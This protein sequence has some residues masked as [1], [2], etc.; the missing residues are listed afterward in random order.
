MTRTEDRYANRRRVWPWVLGVVLVVALAVAA[1][2]YF[3][4]DSDAPEARA[5]VVSKAYRPLP[6]AC[7]DALALAR[8]MAAHVG[9]LSAAVN[10]HADLMERLDL[11]LEGKPGGLSGKQVYEQGQVQMKVFE[12]HGPDAEVQV[13]RFKEVARRCP[14]K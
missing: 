4:E 10:D 13:R 2:L 3:R 5:A 12:A 14:L 11:F 7:A 9:P 8:L 1:G 6:Q